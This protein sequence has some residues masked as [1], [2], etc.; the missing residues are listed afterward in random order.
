MSKTYVCKNCSRVCHSASELAGHLGQSDHDTIWAKG[1]RTRQANKVYK[2]NHRAW[3]EAFRRPYEST[4]DVEPVQ[5]KIIRFFQE[6]YEK[7]NMGFND[8]EILT[9]VNI[10]KRQVKVEAK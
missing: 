3:K 7:Q 10:A 1:Y 8:N 9:M 5:K 2:E 4:R 6:L